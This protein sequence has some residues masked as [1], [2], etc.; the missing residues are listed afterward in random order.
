[1]YANRCDE[2]LSRNVEFRFDRLRVTVSSS[3]EVAAHPTHPQFYRESHAPHWTRASG[4]ESL[5]NIEC[6]AFAKFLRE[7][8]GLLGNAKRAR[9]S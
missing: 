9:I 1:M 5:A 2:S 7:L 4:F 3:S 6:V 8:Q